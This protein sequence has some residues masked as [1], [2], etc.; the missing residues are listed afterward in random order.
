MPPD[1]RSACNNLYSEILHLLSGLDLYLLPVQYF[2]VLS[3]QCFPLLPV[4]ISD[5][6]LLV[7]IADPDLL[8]AAMIPNPVSG[9][10]S[11]SHFGFCFISRS[12]FRSISCSVSHIG[13]CSTILDSRPTP[14]PVSIPDSVSI[15][16]SLR[17]SLPLLLALLPRGIALYSRQRLI[18]GSHSA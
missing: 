5:S 17:Q 18:I 14:V 11:V 1:C 13:F 12:T 15:S 10:C 3:V 16:P 7:L 9:P 8:F 4:H 2:H 6:D